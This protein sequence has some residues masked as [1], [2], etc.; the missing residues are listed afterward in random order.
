VAWRF[1]QACPQLGLAIFVVILLNGLFAF[2]QE[3]RAEK[4]GDRLGDLLPRRATVIRAGRTLSIDAVELVPD[5]VVVLG[6]GD[7][8]SADLRLLDAHALLLD[9]STLTGESVPT[10]SG[11]GDCVFAGTFAVEGEATGV[12]TATGAST[13]LAKIAQLTTSTERP[14]LPLVIELN[15]LVRVIAGISLGTGAFFMVIAWLV[16]IRL[17]DAYLFALG[18]TVALVPEGL[19]PTISLALAIGTR[20]M[21][22]TSRSGAFTGDRT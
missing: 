21:P 20:R 11:P 2:I 7:R 16:G 10:S 4:A 12:V 22:A 3:Y 17:T 1:S 8:I 19:L 9:T 18:V 6:A 5:D 14:P 13:R 15:R